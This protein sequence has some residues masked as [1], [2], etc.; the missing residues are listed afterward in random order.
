MCIYTFF[1]DRGLIFSTVWWLKEGFCQQSGVF[2]PTLLLP[3]CLRNK[4][5]HFLRVLCRFI[6]PNKSA[7]AVCRAERFY[8]AETNYKQVNTKQENFRLC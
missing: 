7:L 8:F 1:K 2:N 5:I 4:G 3:S 6:C